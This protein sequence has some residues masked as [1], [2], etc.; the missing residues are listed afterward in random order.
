[1]EYVSNID[2]NWNRAYFRYYNEGNH[3]GSCGSFEANG[4]VNLFSSIRQNSFFSIMDTGGN[5]LV[6]LLETN[7]KRFKVCLLIVNSDF[8]YDIKFEF[9][10]SNKWEINKLNG[11]TGIPKD[12]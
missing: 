12:L 4:E 10:D 3:F 9:D 2:P 6:K 7:G 8:S 5:K 11:A 1:M